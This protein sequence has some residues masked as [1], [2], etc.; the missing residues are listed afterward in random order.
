MLDIEI[1]GLQEL[2]AKTDQVITDLHGK[3]MLDGMR[4]ATMLVST[5]A[6]KLAPV[7]RGQLRSSITPE[8]RAQG[9]TVLGVVGT[10][11][12]YAPYQ[13]TGTRPFW[14]PIAALEVWAR[15]HGVSAYVVARAIAR[16]GIKPK[17]YMQGAF[18]AKKDD[19]VALIGRVVSRIVDQ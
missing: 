10:N 9:F 17:R 3:P 2:Q 5:E 18:D 14:P 7:D 6:K 12:L 15:R 19:V 8:V 4:A 1:R 13:E 16:H 11:K